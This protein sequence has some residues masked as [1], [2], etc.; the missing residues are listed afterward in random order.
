M[1]CHVKNKAPEDKTGEPRQEN[2]SNDGRDN[3]KKNAA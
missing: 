2:T 1:S 3:V